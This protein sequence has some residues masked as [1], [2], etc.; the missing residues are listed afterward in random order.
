MKIATMGFACL[1]AL[2]GLFAALQWYQSAIK[3]PPPIDILDNYVRNPQTHLTP[4]EQWLLDVA[5]KNKTAAIWTA[6]AVILGPSPTF[7]AHYSNSGKIRSSNV[8][9]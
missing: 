3:S 8:H 1:S 5:G 4:L 2:T 7:L 6:I 9:P